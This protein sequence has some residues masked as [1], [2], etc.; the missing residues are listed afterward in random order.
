MSFASYQIIT[1]HFVKVR[2]FSNIS[3]K[4]SYHA[5]T[6]QQIIPIYHLTPQ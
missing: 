4:V 2:L 1:S 6:Y 5:F 3:T